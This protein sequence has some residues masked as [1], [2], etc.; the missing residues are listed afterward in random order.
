MRENA[1]PNATTCVLEAAYELPEAL[2]GAN[3][4]SAA[5]KLLELA[6]I[7]HRL[8]DVPL[9]QVSAHKSVMCTLPQRLLP[10]RGKR[11]LNGLPIA[12]VRGESFRNCL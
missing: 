9:C 6:V 10:Q 5:Q 2:A 1:D 11:D 4:K 12:T 8:N 3:T 7:R